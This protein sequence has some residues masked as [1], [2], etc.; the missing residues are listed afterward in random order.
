MNEVGGLS[1]LTFFA[2][3]SPYPTN[4]MHSYEVVGTR[5]IQELFDIVVDYPDR[6]CKEWVAGVMKQA[7]AGPAVMEGPRRP[8]ASSLSPH[9]STYL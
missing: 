1:L 6:W 9:P 5:L 7:D 4:N 3:L 2:T 8:S